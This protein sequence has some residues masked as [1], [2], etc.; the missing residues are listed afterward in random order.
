MPD[1]RVYINKNVFMHAMG[2]SEAPSS[3]AGMH[4]QKSEVNT[5]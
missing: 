4:T 3:R 5:S 1:K 2:G